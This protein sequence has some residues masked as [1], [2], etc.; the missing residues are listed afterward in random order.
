MKT[1]TVSLTSILR[2]KQNTRDAHSHVHQAL[3]RWLSEELK[4]AEEDNQLFDCETKFYGYSR[5]TLQRNLHGVQVS[6]DIKIGDIEGKPFYFADVRLI[7]QY[8]RPMLPAT[9]ALITDGD[10]ARL[11]AYIADFILSVQS[12]EIEKN[13]R[14]ADAIGKEYQA[15]YRV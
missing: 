3:G 2:E 6:L 4:A 1:A 8:Y 12:G 14:F 13:P 15:P 5:V 7:G 9:G 11:L 10:K